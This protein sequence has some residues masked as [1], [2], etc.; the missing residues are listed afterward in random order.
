M[1][2]FESKTVHGAAKVLCRS[3]SFR[4]CD[5][6][7]ICRCTCFVRIDIVL[8]DQPICEILEIVLEV[9]DYHVWVAETKRAT[10]FGAIASTVRGASYGT[11][12]SIAREQ[13]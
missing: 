1:D 3:G 13:K 2:E 5:T 9:F 8:L 4:F 12:L 6:I 11:I 7:F 10:L